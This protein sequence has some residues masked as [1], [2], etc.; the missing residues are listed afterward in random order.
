[1]KE[2][3][4]IRKDLKKKKPHFMRQDAHKRKRLKNSWR[5]SRGSQSKMR[6]GLKGYRRSITI[7]W[8]SPRKVYG[9]SKEGLEKITVNNVNDLKK[10]DAKKEGAL[11]S[12]SVGL[13]K[14]LD[15]IKEAENLKI[16]ILNIK[17]PQKFVKDSEESMKKK[18]EEKEARQKEKEKK[19]TDKKKEKK[20]EEKTIEEA[21]EVTEEEKKKHDKEDKDKLLTKKQ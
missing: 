17:D 9:L 19:K 8:G 3:L 7:G 21:V 4:K 20:K 12:G 6:Q 10:M 15:I 5:K 11:I 13:R 14:K 2:L 1:M 18:K 16:K